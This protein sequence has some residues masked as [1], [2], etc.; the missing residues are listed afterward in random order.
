[1]AKNYAHFTVPPVVPFF[2]LICSL[3]CCF[4]AECLD[5]RQP[6]IEEPEPEA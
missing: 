2:D 4:P 3:S 5:W 6:L 1:M